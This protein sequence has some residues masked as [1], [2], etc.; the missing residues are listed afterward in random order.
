M[1]NLYH[2]TSGCIPNELDHAKFKYHSGCTDMHI[3][4]SICAKV[5]FSDCSN[6][7]S[8]IVLGILGHMHITSTI[9]SMHYSTEI[10]YNPV[11]SK[12]LL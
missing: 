10:H 9:V 1:C 7:S 12:S 3:T 4:G 6:Q 11:R 8:T 2:S 5:Q